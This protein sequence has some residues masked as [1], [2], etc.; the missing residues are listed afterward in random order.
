MFTKEV[1]FGASENFKIFPKIA[2]KVE[3]VGQKSKLQNAAILIVK[4][5]MKK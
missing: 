1:I 4:V 2:V 5:F 3:G